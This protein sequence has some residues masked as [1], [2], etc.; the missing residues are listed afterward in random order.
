MA[1]A[2]AGQDVRETNNH[3]THALPFQ[4]PLQRHTDRAKASWSSVTHALPFQNPLQRRAGRVRRG[5]DRRRDTRLSVPEPVATE[6]ARQ[7]GTLTEEESDT[8]LSVPEPV[9]T[10]VRCSDTRLS[11]PEPVATVEIAK[12]FSRSR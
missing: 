1:A 4:K 6:Q 5:L 10:R 12:C 11:V 8:R 3:V 2:L 9:A 7:M